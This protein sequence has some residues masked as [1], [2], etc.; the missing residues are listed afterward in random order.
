MD[1]FQKNHVTQTHMI[2]TILV[3]G[4]HASGYSVTSVYS[5]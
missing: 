3:C 2:M 4:R 5:S 1:L